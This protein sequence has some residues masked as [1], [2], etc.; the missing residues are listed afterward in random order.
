[1]G[2]AGLTG[3]RPLKRGRQVG[4]Q[5]HLVVGDVLKVGVEVKPRH[6]VRRVADNEVVQ[7]EQ[8]AFDVSERREHEFV[9]SHLLYPHVA[10]HA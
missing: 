2:R 7:R 8:T 10:A 9:W 5:S 3:K 1:M 6:D 4:R